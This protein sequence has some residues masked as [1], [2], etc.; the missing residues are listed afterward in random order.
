V[1]TYVPLALSL[2]VMAMLLSLNVRLIVN[3]PLLAPILPLNLSNS[4]VSEKTSEFIDRKFSQ[5][6]LIHTQ[7]RPLFS[8]SRRVWIVPNQA[9]AVE[10]SLPEPVIEEAVVVAQQLAVTLVG[11]QKTPT[12]E[13]VLLM[14]IGASDAIWVNAGESIDQWTVKSVKSDSV[15][16]ANGNQI[17][18]L[19][20]Y[21][22]PPALAVE[23]KQ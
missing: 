19:E 22:S 20:L 2:I 16:M 18:K 23:I 14:R 3:P 8:P 11:I 7:T 13:R 9:V 6:T 21:P 15:E 4:G 1:K 17:L 5:T 12:K 10:P